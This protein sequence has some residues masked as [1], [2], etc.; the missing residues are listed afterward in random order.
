MCQFF[1]GRQ[2]Q[3]G[4]LP[5]ATVTNQ[6]VLLLSNVLRHRKRKRPKIWR[7][8]LGGP[9]AHRLGH[10]LV[11]YTVAALSSRQHIASTDSS[12]N[13][14]VYL[15]CSHSPCKQIRQLFYFMQRTY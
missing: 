11:P 2:Q 4:I 1:R 8:T 12:I 13:C 15:Y 7:Y 10:P 6:N 5:A 9:T 14:V 3:Q